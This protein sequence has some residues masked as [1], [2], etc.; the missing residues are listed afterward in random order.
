MK[1]V[2]ISTSSLY[3]LLTILSANFHFQQPLQQT[4]GCAVH[5]VKHQFRGD[6]VFDCHPYV[7]ETMYIILYHFTNEF[8]Q[9]S[10]RPQYPSETK[11]HNTEMFLPKD[12]K[13]V[14]SFF[15][16]L[17]FP[18]ITSPISP[19]TSAQHSRGK[20]K[21]PF[22]LNSEVTQLLRKRQIL[23][24]IK[25]RLQLMPFIMHLKA[26]QVFFSFIIL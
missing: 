14:V 25:K 3:V 22:L 9:C 7:N 26:P 15:L 23:T 19:N 16:A 11:S 20:R 21:H 12:L 2:E 24:Q 5:L 6:H 8:Y 10:M 18:A 13:I 4:C 17:S 1:V